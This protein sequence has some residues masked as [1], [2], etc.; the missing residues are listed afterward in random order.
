MMNP[1]EPSADVGVLVGRFQV[2]DL[3]QGHRDLIA[4]VR[5]RHKRVLLF[6]GSTPGVLVTRRN[7]LD[8]QTRRL[9]IHEHFPEVDV[10]PLPDM[11][12]DAQWSAELD[13]RIGEVSDGRSVLL[14]GSRD[15]FVPAYS[16]RHSVIE[17]AS[18]HQVS[19]TEVRKS[20]SNEVRRSADFR[21]GVIYAAYNRHAAAFPTVDAACV[22]GRGTAEAEIL[23]ARKKTDEANRWRFFGGFVDPKADASLEFAASRELHEES[24]GL[25]VHAQPIYLGSAR[26]DDWRYRSEDDGIITTFFLFDYFHG[27][28]RPSDD[29]DDV[30]WFRLDG[31]QREDIVPSH[32]PLYELL[33]AHL[34]GGESHA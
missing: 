20:V 3:H 24:G 14:Y 13:R 2:H 16:G 21:R 17:L 7:P 26:I 19:G 25:A 18:R 32:H 8:F 15:G 22:R 6:L 4:A 27:E 12:D 34:N 10:L 1:V 28:A 33:I 29:V 5:E 30:R 11:P 31:L 23:L 9:M